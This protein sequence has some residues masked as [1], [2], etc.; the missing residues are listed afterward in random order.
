M[1]KSLKHSARLA[2][3]GMSHQLGG[4]FKVNQPKANSQITGTEG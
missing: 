2:N 3:F 1:H 4:N